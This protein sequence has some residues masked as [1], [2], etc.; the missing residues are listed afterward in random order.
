[1]EVVTIHNLY[2]NNK[3]NYQH[4]FKCRVRRLTNKEK[5]LLILEH[6]QHK[7]RCRLKHI[8]LINMKNNKMDRIFKLLDM[9]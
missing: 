2:I 5:D 9:R 3:T 4:L 8:E 1:M 7:Q 6:N